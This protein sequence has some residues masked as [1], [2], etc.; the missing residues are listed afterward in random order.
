MS[1]KVKPMNW[2]KAQRIL[3]SKQVSPEKELIK[4]RVQKKVQVT[5]ELTKKKSPPKM[6]KTIV[7]PRT[8]PSYPKKTP[9]RF[10]RKQESKPSPKPITKVSS[11]KASNLKSSPGYK[12]QY[13]PES[14]YKKSLI[15]P[16]TKPSPFKK[17]ELTEL[18]RKQQS[19]SPTKRGLTKV[20]LKQL[21]PESDIKSKY[22]YE[23]IDL[24][25]KKKISVTEKGSIF[26]NPPQ[27]IK[28]S[29]K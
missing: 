26:K 7:L 3:L 6:K 19:K 29:K 11:P 27:R 9:K 18:L 4:E 1:T 8:S 20:N 21:F 15:L 17:E 24:S 16:I 5:G 2:G 10:A 22:L 23:K 28:V 25:P 13:S 14:K 12:F